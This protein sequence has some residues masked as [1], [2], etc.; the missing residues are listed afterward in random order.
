MLIDCCNSDTGQDRRREA[1]GL[2]KPLLANLYM[3]RF[4]LGWKMLGLEQSLSS[5]IVTYADDLVI[6][7]RTALFAV[8]LEGA[9]GLRRR[10][11]FAPSHVGRQRMDGARWSSSSDENSAVRD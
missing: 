3:R 9:T 10:V 6:L 4:V 8:L 5:R 2:R 7:C 1:Q 11:H